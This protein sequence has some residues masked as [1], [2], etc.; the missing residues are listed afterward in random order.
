MVDPDHRIAVRCVNHDASA[1]AR[2]V[3]EASCVGCGICE[4]VCPVGAIH[5]QDGCAR[6]DYRACIACGMCATK[7]PRGAI[8]D[9][10]GLFADQ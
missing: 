1:V 2:K 9:A 8:S 6:I 3:C 4:R 7:C 5:V 10:I